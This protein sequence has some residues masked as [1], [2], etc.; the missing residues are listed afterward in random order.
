MKFGEYFSS[1][2]EVVPVEKKENDEGGASWFRNKINE[3]FGLGKRA[4]EDPLRELEEIA[5][6]GGPEEVELFHQGQQIFNSHNEEIDGARAEM[7]KR[8]WP[9]AKNL[10]T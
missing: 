8:W 9:A 2:K 6:K 5:A 3:V 10:Q 4:G 7:E 1:K